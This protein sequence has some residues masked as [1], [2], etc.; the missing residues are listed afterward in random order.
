MA[1]I[2]I[3]VSDELELCTIV[4]MVWLFL[5]V[6]GKKMFILF[7]RLVIA[8]VNLKLNISAVELDEELLYRYSATS[9]H[10]C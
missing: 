1:G 7:K 5:T 10:L 6:I 2:K 3:S 4:V 9:F 8:K